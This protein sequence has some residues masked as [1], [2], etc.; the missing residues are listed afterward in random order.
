[1]C[2]LK[3]FLLFY[4]GWKANPVEFDSVFNQSRH[5]ISFGSPDI[6]PIF[7]RSIPHSTWGTYPHEYEDFATG[8]IYWQFGISLL[9]P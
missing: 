6:V 7:C 1:M 4:A 5:T 8:L 9:K 2:V 3:L